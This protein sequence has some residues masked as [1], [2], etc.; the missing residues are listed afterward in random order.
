[1]GISF[2]VSISRTDGRLQARMIDFKKKGFQEQVYGGKVVLVFLS[3]KEAVDFTRENV[4]GNEYYEIEKIV[5]GRWVW[6]TGI[7]KGGT[8]GKKPKRRLYIGNRFRFLTALFCVIFSQTLNAQGYDENKDYRPIAML[9]HAFAMVE[10][11][12][13]VYAENGNCI[14]WLQISPIM[15][16]EANRIIG[17][18]CFNNEDRYDMQ[19][20]LAIFVTVMREKNPGLSVRKACDIWNPRAGSDYYERVRN[21]YEM[22]KKGGKQ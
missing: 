17:W 5:N 1:M 18:P 19:G 13:N 21:C 22:I 10:S 8:S 15:V 4:R 20:S 12:D 9:A 6:G 11:G 7:N 16:K 2:I 3:W 14:G